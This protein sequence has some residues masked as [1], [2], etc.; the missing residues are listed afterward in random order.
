MSGKEIFRNNL[1]N[2]AAIGKS[3][4]IFFLLLR[5]TVV[6]KPL[7]VTPALLNSY[8]YLFGKVSLSKLVD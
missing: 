2:I 4:S 8:D 1:A 7:Y 6:E 5:Y 3:A